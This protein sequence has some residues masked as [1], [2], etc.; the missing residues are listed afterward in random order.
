MI[1]GYL[2]NLLAKFR[3]DND[4]KILTEVL[5]D[6]RAVFSSFGRDIY[7]SDFVN[8]CID[9]IATEVSKIDVISVTEK[10]SGIS[11]QNDDITRLF[12]YQPNPL[13]TT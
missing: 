1:F 13:Q 11:R 9:R 7:F 8:N 3:G 4:K 12:R 5:S 2:K 6:S 10:E